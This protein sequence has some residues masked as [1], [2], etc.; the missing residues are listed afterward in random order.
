MIFIFHPYSQ[1]NQLLQD[2]CKEGVDTTILELL[3]SE[4]PSSCDVNGRDKVNV[5]EYTCSNDMDI[6]VFYMYL[7]SQHGRTCLHTIC[8][9]FPKVR[10]HSSI[11]LYT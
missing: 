3:L 1:N 8:A 9:S 7:L 2:A 6:M 10:F 5:A 4:S 11:D